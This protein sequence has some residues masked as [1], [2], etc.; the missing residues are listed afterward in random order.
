MQDD[1]GAAPEPAGTPPPTPLSETS[2]TRRRLTRLGWISALAVLL[3][4]Q[5]WVLLKL[6]MT[7]ATPGESRGTFTLGPFSE[8]PPGSVTHFRKARVFLV[9]AP[10]GLLA[11]GDECT[12]QQCPLLYV[13]ERHVLQ[14]NCHGARFAPTGEVLDG[15]APHPLP[16]YAVRLEDGQVS[17][18]TTRTLNRSAS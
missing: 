6:V 4:G 11:L 1:T 18:D 9:H 10:T 2:I 13:A 7:P 14:C 15:P 17:V 16:R 8:F 12:H 5:L 3:G